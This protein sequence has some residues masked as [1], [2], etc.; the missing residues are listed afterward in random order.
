MSEVS[1]LQQQSAALQAEIDQRDAKCAMLEEAQVG[2]GEE[3]MGWG[4]VRGPFK[5][6]WKR[7]PWGVLGGACSWGLWERGVKCAML[8]E[9]Q[10]RGHERAGN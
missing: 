6:V 5:S 2:R 4:R 1:S 8:E 3:W 10:V 7:F 9:A